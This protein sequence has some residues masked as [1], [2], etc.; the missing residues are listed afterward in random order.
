[1]N[2]D[3]KDLFNEKSVSAALTILFKHLKHNR[4]GDTI[5][6]IE[7][8][9]YL[10]FIGAYDKSIR[11]VNKT[12]HA[13]NLIEAIKIVRLCAA[14][15]E[16]MGCLYYGM[17]VATFLTEENKPAL[18]ELLTHVCVASVTEYEKGYGDRPDGFVLAVKVEDHKALLKSDNGQHLYGN[19][20][21]FS[22]VNNFYIRELTEKGRETMRKALSE[23]KRAIW[24]HSIN[25][26]ILPVT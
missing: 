2:L 1:M 3:L 12:Q 14:G 4:L 24:V 21:H 15:I 6:E 7:R 19:S 17:N 8:V 23:G 9:A 5:K 22:T 16:R 20:D 13:N 18:P 26:L 25:E 10:S 11:R